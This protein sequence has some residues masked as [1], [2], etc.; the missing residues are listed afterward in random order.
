MVQVAIC[1]GGLAGATLAL[2]L[3]KHGISCVIYERETKGFAAGGNIALSP[4]ALR[5][6]DH[7]GVYDRVRNIGYAFETVAFT[8]GQGV[9]LAR[10]Y[11]GSY[12]IYNFP[13]L[14]IQR[15]QLREALVQQCRQVGI[16]IYYEKKC[17]GI[18]SEDDHS[19]TVEFEDGDTVTADYIVGCDGIHSKIRP[20]VRPHAKPEFQGLTGISGTFKMSDLADVDLK[21]LHLPCFLFGAT[22]SFAIMPATN[23]G[24]GISYFATF[25]VPEKSKEEW[26]AF[27]AD[28]ENL[29]EMLKER[30]LT[31]SSRWPPIVKALCERAPPAS[32]TNWP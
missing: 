6:L 8:N 22:G 9:E 16:E 4:N 20:F 26:A 10:V 18:T 11:N 21:G 30:F 13:A 3:Q 27:D 31:S 12:K 28:K 25:E 15:S 29:S 7:V 2:C 19:A 5:V 14:R 1:G 23:A 24:E 32:L 17:V